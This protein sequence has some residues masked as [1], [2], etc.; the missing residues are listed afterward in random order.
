MIAMTSTARLSRVLL[1]AERPAAA[2]V[3]GSPRIRRYRLAT[4]RQDARDARFAHLRHGH[5]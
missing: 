1:V 3:P 2:T 5:D 4:L